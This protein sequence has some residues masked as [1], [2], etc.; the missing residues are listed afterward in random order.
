M[1]ACAVPWLACTPQQPRPPAQSP[2]YPRSGDF[3]QELGFGGGTRHYLLHLPPD[4]ARHVPLPL[5][6][7][8]HGGGGDAKDF[9][10]AAGLDA[11]ADALGWAVAYPDGSGKLDHRLLTW[12]AGTCCGEA[13][14]EHVDDVGFAVALLADLARDLDLDRTRIYAVGHSNGGMM[15]Y[16][17]AAREG[18]RIAA[19]VSVAGPDMSDS[20]PSGPPV[21]VLHIHSVDDPRASYA[22]GESRTLAFISHHQSF[23]SVDDT[24][25]RWRGRDGCTGEGKVVDQRK[26]ESHSAE[27]VDFGPCANGADVLLWR[28]H[29]PG[30]GWPGGH[31]WLSAL[32][33]GPETKVI[34]AAEEIFRF[35][36]RFSRPDAPPLR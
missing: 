36:P 26:L 21:P 35:L 5:V 18:A 32:V 6:L 7:A 27:L 9:Q 31:S 22:G 20:F 3:A 34:R 24:L 12:N 19:V 14:A 16:R 23:R 2:R 29:G 10:R 25:A 1:L 11:Q 4:Y 13:Q 17:L 28:M 8:F 33:I 15:A 30:H